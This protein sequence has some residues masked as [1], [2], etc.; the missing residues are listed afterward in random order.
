MWKWREQE[1]MLS[2]GCNRLFIYL[3]HAV[4][5]SIGYN[6]RLSLSRLWTPAM[7]GAGGSGASCC[8]CCGCRVMFCISLTR[9]RQCGLRKRQCS[10]PTPCSPH[11]V[12][13]LL[14]VLLHLAHYDASSPSRAAASRDFAYICHWLGSWRA[15]IF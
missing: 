4:P 14:L 5:P 12:S 11:P 15:Q 8:Y 1:S 13:R 3:C 9:E 10:A 7:A 6:W 2:P